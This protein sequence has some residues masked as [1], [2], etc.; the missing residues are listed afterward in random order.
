MDAIAWIAEQRIREAQEKGALDNLPG[1]GR[2]LRLEDD[3]HIPPDL[4]MAYTILRNAGY[5]PPEVA[6]RNDVQSLRDLLAQCTD[7]QEALRLTRKLDVL[8]ARID[9]RRG[10]PVSLRD[11]AY[12]A[13]VAQ[14]LGAGVPSPT[15]EPTA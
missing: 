9:E 10:R 3:S 15:N 6:D 1:Q 5:V 12:H 2:P 8:L 4:R 14:R 11:N 13:K 7:E